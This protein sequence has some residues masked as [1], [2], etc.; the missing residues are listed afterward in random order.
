MI[1]KIL[2]INTTVNTGSTGR[3]AEDIGRVIISEGHESYIAYSRPG[4]EKSKS[5]LIKIGTKADV[6][7]HGI[8]T[9]LFDL[10][11]FGSKAV[12]QNF[13]K[14]LDHVNPDVIGLHNLHGY[15]LNIEVLFSYLKKVQKPVVWTFH[16]CWPFTGHCSYFDSVNCERWISGC[17]SCPLKTKY[18]AS[19]GLDNSKFNYKKKR[20]LFTGLNNLT[21]V[22]PSKWLAELAGKSFL[23]DYP[24]EVIHNGIDLDTFRVNDDSLPVNLKNS[25]KK[26]VLG[27]ASI[28]DKRK[29]L[30]D[31]VKLSKI[32][33]GKYNIVLV[34]LSN[35]QIKSLPAEIT[36]I[37]RTES[38]K[39]L[40]ALYSLADVFVNPTLSDNFPTTNI[41]ALACGTPVVTYNTGGSPEAIDNSTGIVIE[42]GD[43][44]QVHQSVLEILCKD[45]SDYQKKCRN[46]AVKYFNKKDRYMDYLNLY[47]QKCELL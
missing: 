40:A 22:T 23:G 30:E 7:L 31:F 29:G 6:Y 21:I 12:T 43:I 45:K 32:S 47:E 26:I 36:G 10:H 5:Q 28:W 41:E 42:K 25:G 17:Y 35:A 19:Y 15:Y 8:L 33:G 18:P 37:A 27:V 20:E 24:I 38:V 14:K 1:M 2:Q 11:G 44:E 34:G 3:I 9:R 39:E 16:D 46:R 13:I 4:S